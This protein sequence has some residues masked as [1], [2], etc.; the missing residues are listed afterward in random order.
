MCWASV[1]KPVYYL[2]NTERWSPFSVFGHDWEI[3]TSTAV[4]VP[5]SQ[6]N[7]VLMWIQD[8]F[9]LNERSHLNQY[10]LDLKCDSFITLSGSPVFPDSL[11]APQ[12]HTLGMFNKFLFCFVVKMFCLCGKW[13]CRVTCT[14]GWQTDCLIPVDDVYIL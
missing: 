9:W 7:S 11:N 14:G 12:F 5:Q 3:K 13:H 10:H 4:G 6:K 8:S 1:Q 2:K